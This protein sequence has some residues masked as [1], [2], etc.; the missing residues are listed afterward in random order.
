MERKSQIDAFGAACLI[1][2][3]ALLAFNQVVIKVT[4]GGLQPVLFAGL[5]SAGAI[6]CIY[7]WMRWRGIPITLDQN[8]GPGLLIGVVFALEFLC[9][10]NALDLTTVARTSVIFYTMPFWLAVGARIWLG[11][12]LG[13][14]K[15]LGLGLAVFGVALALLD[16][17]SGGTLE[18]DLYA[19]G[20]AAGWAIIALLARGTSLREVRPE[21]QLFWQVLVSAPILLLLAPFF[22]DLIRDLQPI[23]LWGLAFQTVVIVSAGFIFWLWLLSIYPA[24]PVGSFSFL[25][26]IFTVCLGWLLLGEP[27][28]PTLGAA[29]GLVVLGLLMI[30][31]P[32][33]S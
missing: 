17:T 27:V 24:G 31:W 3:S 12:T 22:G 4:N 6:F 7:L 23:H 10:F 14:L 15:V 20:G 9:L 29:L 18:G 13:V 25:S 5:R 33:R 11:E 26:P 32:R 21:M 16:D 2:F 30:N 8:R 19:L 28:S 1:G